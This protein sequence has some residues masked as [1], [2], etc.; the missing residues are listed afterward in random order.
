MTV[1]ISCE[2]ALLLLL[3]MLMQMLILAVIINEEFFQQGIYCAAIM[4]PFVQFVLAGSNRGAEG[5]EVVGVG[6]GVPLPAGG[7]SVEGSP[8]PRKCFSVPYQNGVFWYSLH[9][10]DK[11]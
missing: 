4:S 3:L 9:L 10:G 6:I 7:G 1:T 11:F 5:T 2:I 8:L